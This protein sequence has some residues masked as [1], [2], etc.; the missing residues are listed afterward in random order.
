MSGTM[1]PPN[2]LKYPVKDV[3]RPSKFTPERR[4]AIIDAIA[5]RVPYELAAEGNGICEE[6]FYEWLR[7]AREDEANGIDSEYSKFS[8][9]I[10]RAELQKVKEHNNEI[11]SKPERWQADAWILERRWGKYY[12]ANY[13]LNEMGKRLDKIEQGTSHHEEKSQKSEET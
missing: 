12:N 1:N 5:H 2:K 9:D 11:A 8:E 3:G 10:K 13:E 6:T 4:A 7:I